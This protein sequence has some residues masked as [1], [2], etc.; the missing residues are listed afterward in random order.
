MPLFTRVCVNVR[1]SEI[2]VIEFNLEVDQELH[3]SQNLQVLSS[4]NHQVLML[5]LLSQT[6]VHLKT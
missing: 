1:T 5:C 4:L 2:K 6:P 3:H